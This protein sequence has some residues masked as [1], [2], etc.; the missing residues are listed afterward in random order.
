MNNRLNVNV[1]VLPQN[2]IYQDIGE[3]RNTTS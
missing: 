2:R 3:H 1:G